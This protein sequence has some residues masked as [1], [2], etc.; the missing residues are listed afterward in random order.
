[1]DTDTDG[2]IAEDIRAIRRYA[3]WILAILV[4]TIVLPVVFTLGLWALNSVDGF[5]GRTTRS[6]QVEPIERPNR[7]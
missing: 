3:G 4:V 5:S 6:V 7:H 1:M 2:R